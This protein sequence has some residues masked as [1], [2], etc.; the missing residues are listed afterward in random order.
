MLSMMNRIFVTVLSVYLFGLAAESGASEPRPSLRILSDRPLP[1]VLAGAVDVRWA[2]DSS[3]YLAALRSGAVRISVDLDLPQISKPIPGADEPRGSFAGSIAASSEYLVTGG[4]FW[5]TWRTMKNSVRAEE[6]FD[7]I[8]DFDVA[9]DRF[10][11][12]AARRGPKGEFAPEGAI[13]WIGSLRQGLSD[14]QPVAYDATG[15]GARNLGRCSNFRIGGSRFLPDGSFVLVPGVQPGVSLYSPQGRLLRTWDSA[16][17][18]L[19][20]D[21]GSLS[22]EKAQQYGVN[23][24]QRMAWLNQRR[25]LDEILPLPQGPALLIRSVFQGQVSWELKVLTQSGG[26]SVYRLPVRSQN[27]RSR[28]R[29]DVRGGNIVLVMSAFEKDGMKTAVPRVIVAR[30]PE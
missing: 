11:I 25:I 30:L 12:L 28:L 27:E 26:V 18:G 2:D 9:G 1:A 5:V 15:P 3:V 10:L 7:S 14:L 13:A 6:A 20:T 16:R 21:C 17:L 8:H 24:L 19:D 23:W 22:V 4:P 29:G